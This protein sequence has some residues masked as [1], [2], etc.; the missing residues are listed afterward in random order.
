MAGRRTFRLTAV[1]S[2]AALG[3]ALLVCEAMQSRAETASLDAQ[4]TRWNC[5]RQESAK[6]PRCQEMAKQGPM[7]DADY[8]DEAVSVC[9]GRGL[10]V[11]A[12]QAFET[13]LQ[14]AM[15]A[16]VLRL[17]LFLIGASLVA[18][19]AVIRPVMRVRR[20]SISA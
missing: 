13:Y 9:A 20:K 17:V 4:Q 5:W 6:V 11:Q 14:W 1:L 19:L 16:R 15:R 18:W 8:C 7:E 12:D 2:L 3:G 10:T